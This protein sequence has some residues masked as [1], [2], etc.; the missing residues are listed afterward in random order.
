MS[1]CESFVAFITGTPHTAESIV[2]CILHDQEAM[3]AFTVAIRE[4]HFS[5]LS[6]SASKVS[7]N[8]A[9]VI[10]ADFT[11]TGTETA[12]VQSQILDRLQLDFHRQMVLPCCVQHTDQDWSPSVN[13]FR[14]VC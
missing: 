5:H 12:E 10:V 2:A 9:H 13:P 8:L 4:A 3:A 7:S 1:Y 11:C 6:T 14:Y